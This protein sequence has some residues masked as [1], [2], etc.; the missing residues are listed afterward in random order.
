[1]TEEC[2]KIT[3]PILLLNGENEE[4]KNVQPFFDGIPKIKWY[5]FAGSGHAASADQPEKYKNV[6]WG[7]LKA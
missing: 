6:I 2:K 5:V 3:Q 4:A 7:F 1:M